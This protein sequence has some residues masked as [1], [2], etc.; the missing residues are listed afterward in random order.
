MAGFD[1]LAVDLDLLDET[2]ADMARSGEALDVLLD[3]VS[4]RVAALH[5]TWAGS[6]AIA[7]EG[8][9]A[10]WAAGFRDMR[11]ALAAMRAVG[12]TAHD[13]YRDAAATNLQMW[14]QVS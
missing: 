9:Q 4:R 8:A 1:S 3:E 12:R 11:A 6:A 5:V 10:E 2:V 14:E 13:S 7:Q